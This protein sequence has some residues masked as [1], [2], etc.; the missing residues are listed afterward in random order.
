MTWAVDEIHLKG[1]ILE[2]QSHGNLAFI[3]SSY[4]YSVSSS[5]LLLRGAPDK[6]RI[7]CPNFTS[8]RHRKLWVKDLPKV[9]TWLLERESNPWL[10]RWKMSTLPMYQPR[11]ILGL[12]TKHWV[13]LWSSSVRRLQCIPFIPNACSMAENTLSEVLTFV[14]EH[15]YSTFLEPHEDTMTRL[16]S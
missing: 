6:A 5:P 13:L 11:P 8:K 14:S 4:F 12:V 3:H 16:T 9:P 10:F 7:L 15:L 2:T 1:Q